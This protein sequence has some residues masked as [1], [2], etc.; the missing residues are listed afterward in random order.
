MDISINL[1]VV[2][3]L[4]TGMF[5]KIT[6][7][8]SHPATGGI[9]MAIII[10]ILRVFYDSDETSFRR[11]IMESMLC[12]ALTLAGGSAFKM[13]GYGPEAYMFCGGT[14]GFMGSQSVRA[15]AYKWLGRDKET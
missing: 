2:R 14:I 11:I 3:Q 6:D 15:L 1:N 4:S 7:L 8:I 9:V 10:S 5:E 13:M 12:G